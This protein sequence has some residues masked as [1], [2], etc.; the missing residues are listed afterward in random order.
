MADLTLSPEPISPVHASGSQLLDVANW[1]SDPKMNG[2]PPV[3]ANLAPKP[4]P[5]VKECGVLVSPPF[6][7]CQHDPAKWLDREKKL[8]AKV[9]TQWARVK[10]IEK[11]PHKPI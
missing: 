4:A 3:A 5:R 6:Q 7:L 2:G 1:C 10:K 8:M 9:P 11:V